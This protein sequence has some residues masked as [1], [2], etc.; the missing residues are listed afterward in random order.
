MTAEQPGSPEEAFTALFAAGEEAVAAGG[1][2]RPP[3]EAPPELRARLE[4][5]LACAHLLRRALGPP[6]TP[7]PG[8]PPALPATLGAATVPSPAQVNLALPGGAGAEAGSE[9]RPLLWRRLRFAS[10]CPLT[11]HTYFTVTSLSRV[12]GDPSAVSLKTWLYFA[13]TWA[14]CLAT[15]GVAVFLWRSPSLS[16]GR[17]RVLELVVFGLALIDWT[18]MFFWAILVH[19]QL[20]QVYAWGR[21]VDDAEGMLCVLAAA[22]TVP[23]V[24]LIIGYAAV[25]PSGWRRCTAVVSV[26]ALTPVVVATAATGRAL[27]FLPVYLVYFLLP[28]VMCLALVVAIVAYGTHR[29][30]MLRQEAAEARK[31]GRYQLKRLLG[32]GG[33]G[34]VYFAE[35]V[36][37]KQ[38][39]AIKLI[40]PEKAGDAATLRRFEREVQAT[41]QLK[42]WNTVQ[43][44]DYGRAADGA[45][46]YV[47]E[48]L[49]GLTLEQLVSKHGP[50]PPGRVVHLLRQAC[51]ALREA[52]AL[53]LVHRDIKPANVMLCQRGAAH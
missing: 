46:Y 28:M 21:S 38:P 15:L 18:K 17:L 44:Y 11:V 24:F 33:M 9:I 5:D 41:A 32:A 14:A 40:R 4:R 47:M 12:L 16:L 39:C 26:F 2:P 31:L 48:Y 45:F 19:D 42:H 13:P 30:E 22:Y 36:L 8:P 52:H 51:L 53:C 10:L 1:E 35:H 20:V 29:V 23:Y 25:I 6:A 50:L 49:P 3:A 7:G 43:I 27:P 34:Q 37:L